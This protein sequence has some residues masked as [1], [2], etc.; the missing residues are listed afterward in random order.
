M[1]GTQI[2][3]SEPYSIISRPHDRSCTGRHLHDVEHADQARQGKEVWVRLDEHPLDL[4]ELRHRVASLLLRRLRK[5]LREGREDRELPVRHRLELDLE[6]Q[7]WCCSIDLDV[8]RAQVP[9]LVRENDGP[10]IRP[11]ARVTLG[12]QLN[13]W[14]EAT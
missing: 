7:H 13:V 5:A 12:S 11:P 3:D 8:L 14:T 10:E 9:E 1:Q 4:I 6:R 2:Y